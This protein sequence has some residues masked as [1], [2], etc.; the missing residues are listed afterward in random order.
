MI[1]HLY[2]LLFAAVATGPAAPAVISAELAPPSFA[3]HQGVSV[4]AEF[5]PPAIVAELQEPTP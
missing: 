1:G 2:P 5:S 4:S 3:V